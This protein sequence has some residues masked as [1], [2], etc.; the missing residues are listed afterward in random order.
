MEIKG[1]VL[2]SLAS[3]VL[4]IFLKIT[5]AKQ[6]FNRAFSRMD[7][8][9]G[10]LSRPPES[11]FK[12][13]TISTKIIRDR[14]VFV[15]QEEQTEGTTILYLHGGG[16]VFGFSVI[17]WNFIKAIIKKTKAKVIAPD[18]PLAPENTYEECF[19]MLEETYKELVQQNQ[20]IILMGDSAGGGLALALAQKIKNEG[21]KQPEQIIL[22]SPWLDLTLSVDGIE[23]LAKEDCILEVTGLT[24]AAKSFAGSSPLDDPQLSP[25]NGDLEG[26]GEL[27]V[28]IGTKDILL[29]DARRLKSRVTELGLN[30]NYFEY[31]NMLHVWPL[32]GLP[33]SKLAIE[34]IVGL[35][36]VRSIG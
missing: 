26:L 23:E 29:V 2:V 12:E 13:L 24:K 3:E 34:E 5:K 28:F 4:E 19:L 22:I 6:S 17:H 10:V 1:D 31:K 27:S 20:R 7:F 25:I 15:L 35:I 9:R 36:S 14:N 8:S 33:E 32:L 16:F 21:L 30:I 18:Y 11:F